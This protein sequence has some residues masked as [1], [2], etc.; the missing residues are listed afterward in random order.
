[1]PRST[2]ATFSS[3]RAIYAQ[4]DLR[5]GAALW[6]GVERMA[7]AAA[8]SPW[9]RF[10]SSTRL[11]A[12]MGELALAQGDLDRARARARQCLELATETN[13]RKNLVKGWRLAG[14]I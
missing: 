7:R 11:W 5:G 14:A 10:R 12:S 1:M 13:A 4:R 3:R 8:T 2:S 6:D 9:M